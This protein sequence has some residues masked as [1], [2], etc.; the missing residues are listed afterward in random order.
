[1]RVRLVFVAVLLLSAGLAALLVWTAEPDADQAASPR[2]APDPVPI[3][4]ARGVVFDADAPDAAAPDAAPADG[5][6]RPDGS[7]GASV[8]LAEHVRVDPRSAASCPPAM[9][10][11]E[12]AY[13][14]YVAHRCARHVAP[15]DR[16][17]CQ[18]YHDDLLCEGRPSSLH[19][20]I[21]RFEYP[22]LPGVRPVVMASYDEARRACRQEGKRLCE[23]EEWTLACEGKDTWPYPYGLE[24]D[25][26]ACNIDRPVREPDRQALSRPR[27]VAIEVE[28]LDQRASS[29]SMPRCVSPFGVHDMTG[30]VEEWVHNREGQRRS[31]PYSSGLK[32]GYWG[33]V[34]A[35]C[36]PMSTSHNAAFRS[37]RVGLRCCADALDGQPSRQ[38]MSKQT[39]LPRRR[40]L[41]R[42]RR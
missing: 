6:E 11:V 5:G 25:P 29:G 40:R 10:L 32:G 38:L 4:T 26:S 24:R 31:P 19:F 33:P 34:R 18:R 12:G 30:N 2:S 36:R 14:P 27:Q 22:N 9:V 23:A 17:R 8:E 41:V 3:S 39:R 35:R 7:S 21:D 15:N 16:T 13:C 28:R 42:P 1:M 37:Y 20:C